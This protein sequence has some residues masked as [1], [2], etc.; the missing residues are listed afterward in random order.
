[1]DKIKK[2]RI[3]GAFQW[4][5]PDLNRR[6]TDFQSVALPTELSGL[7][8]IRGCK[9]KTE[10]GNTKFS[11]KKNTFANTNACNCYIFSLSITAI[12]P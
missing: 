10:K 11:G 1:M 5:E 9:D 8:V 3:C 4:P 2:P 12:L 7:L 6:H